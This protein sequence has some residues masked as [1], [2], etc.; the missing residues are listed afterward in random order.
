MRSKEKKKPIKIKCT[1]KEI[2]QGEK[3]YG[4]G[5]NDYDYWWYCLDCGK[6]ISQ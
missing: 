4:Y 5:E 6:E 3:Y 2:E 1:H